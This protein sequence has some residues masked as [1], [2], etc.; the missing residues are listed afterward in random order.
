MPYVNNQG[1]RIHYQVEGQGRPLLLH[2]WSLG[3]L[4]DWVEYGYVEAL[5]D[6]YRLILLDARGH[7]RSDKPHNLEAYSL[8]NRVSDIVAVLDDLQV[9]KAS[10]F[11]YSMGGWIGYGIALHAPQRF[12]ALV[13]G[14][15]HPYAQGMQELREVIQ[16][17]IDEGHEAFIAQQKAEFG[18]VAPP[19]EERMRAFD[20]EA[21]MAVCQDR[22]SLE[23]VLPRMSIPCLL[24]VG[25]L[26]EVC[27]LVKK[28]AG[29]IPN[30]YLVTLPGVDHANAFSRIDLIVPKVRQFLSQVI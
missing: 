6:A 13:I 5:A 21:L 24:L 12:Q 10:Y 7:G 8:Q 20:F 25:E 23:F 22:A 27:P 11:G 18:P 14:G 16:L 28:C 19:R 4:D 30:H 2:H 17:G 15:Q 29:V 1:T 3:T 26:D 9:P